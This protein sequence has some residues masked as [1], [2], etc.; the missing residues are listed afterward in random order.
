MQ[1]QAEADKKEVAGEKVI[2][3]LA[4]IITISRIIC[5]IGLLCCP[6][7]SFCFYALYIFC[8]FSDTIDGIIARKTKTV[9][10][11]GARLDTAADIVFVAV[12]LLKILPVI[13]LPTPLWMW[14]AVIIII[15]IGSI[16][17]GFIR[18]KRL[19]SI[20]T[21]LNKVTGCMLFVFPFTLGFVEP[22]YSSAAICF[23]A[24]VSAI[25]EMYYTRTGRI[26]L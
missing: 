4:N 12:A 7:F 25:N 17:L 15:K 8:G 6:M 3:K 23:V 26:V 24:T 5:S 14:I 2:K 19:I 20:H 16:L 11:L 18:S 22:M 10:E 21:V 1:K 13:Y 9:S